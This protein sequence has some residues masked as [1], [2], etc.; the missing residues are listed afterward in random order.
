MGQLIRFDRRRRLPKAWQPYVRRH[1]RAGELRIMVWLGLLLG[2]LAYQAMR[3]WTPIPDVPFAPLP[4]IAKPRPPTPWAQSQRSRDILAGQEDAPVSST[5]AGG[6][7]PTTVSHALV[8]VVDGD[9]FDQGGVRIRI[10]NI[11]TPETH[12]SR[13]ARE[14]EL[15]EQATRRLEA[16]LAAGPF[17]LIAIDRDEDRYGRK[18]RRVVRGDTALG[19]VLIREGLARAYEGGPR[20]GWC[21]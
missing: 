6:R 9:T 10:A 17:E 3:I 11:D 21:G 14:A 7:Q 1:G 2:L 13:C 12:P 16:L 5:P 18:L 15:G 19:E 20:A 4:V 8:R